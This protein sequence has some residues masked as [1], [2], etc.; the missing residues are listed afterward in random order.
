[1]KAEGGRMK[2]PPLVPTLQRG[3]AYL[4]ALR[5]GRGKRLGVERLAVIP[6]RSV[7]TRGETKESSFTKQETIQ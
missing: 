6:T 7:G 2:A 3:N 5:P 1:M 4:D